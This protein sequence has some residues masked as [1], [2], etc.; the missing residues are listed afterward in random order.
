MARRLDCLDY[1]EEL[2]ARA[3]ELLSRIAHAQGHLAGLQAEMEKHLQEVRER[4]GP[5]I[6]QDEAVIAEHEKSLRALM[7]LHD[8]AVFRGKDR[9]DLVHGSL[10]Y[11]SERVVVKAKGMLKRLK[12]LGRK[13][14]IKVVESVK[15]DVLDG[16]SDEELAAAGTRRKVKET[17]T[18]EIRET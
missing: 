18:Y 12:A 1:G 11:L 17:Y 5:D 13:E 2:Q 9:L 6:A 7:R 8:R 16:W 15:W 4:Y 3:D 14:A 10:V